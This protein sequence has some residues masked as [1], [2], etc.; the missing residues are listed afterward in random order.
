MQTLIIT[1]Q[2]EAEANKTQRL[3]LGADRAQKAALFM[4]SS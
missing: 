1:W 3:Q 2:C 4:S